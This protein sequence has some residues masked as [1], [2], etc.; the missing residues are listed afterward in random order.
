MNCKAIALAAILCCASGPAGAQTVGEF[1]VRNA[2]NQ[3]LTCGLARPHGSRVDLFVIRPGQ[4]WTQAAT[5]PTPRRLRCDVNR[6]PLQ[7][8]IHPGVDYMLIEQGGDVVLR[9]AGAG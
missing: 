9:V 5:E 2:T 4:T 1:Q 8:R 7:V 3:N 6:L